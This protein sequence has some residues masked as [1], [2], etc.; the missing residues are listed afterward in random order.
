MDPHELLNLSRYK[1]LIIYGL[2]AALYHWQLKILINLFLSTV[3]LYYLL[4]QTP[5]ILG[6]SAC[7]KKYSYLHFGVFSHDGVFVFG[8]AVL[9]VFSL[10]LQGDQP[11]VQLHLRFRQLL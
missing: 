11:E 7:Y 6:N 9:K 5:S 8:S 10:F 1:H 3:Q 4:V 2:D